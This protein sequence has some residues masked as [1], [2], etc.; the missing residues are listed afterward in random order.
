MNIASEE[1]WGILQL[2]LILNNALPKQFPHW[3]RTGLLVLE[4]GRR[5]GS[6]LGTLR[7][8]FH[9]SLRTQ[10]VSN[11]SIT[12]FPKSQDDPRRNEVYRAKI[13][14]EEGGA[15]EGGV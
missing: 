14:L 13:P 1:L 15:G 8:C 10:Y 4:G 6:V 5:R 9:V 11:T 7:A 2:L 12:R 3:V